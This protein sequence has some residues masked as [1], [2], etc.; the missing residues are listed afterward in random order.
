MLRPL[1]CLVAAGLLATAAMA[2]AAEPFEV[3]VANGPS[4]GGQS[5]TALVDSLLAGDGDFASVGG[6]SSYSASLS[7]LGIEDAIL[8]SSSGSGRSVTVTIPSTGYARTFTGTDADDVAAQVQTWL[9]ESGSA[10]LSRFQAAVNARSRVALLDGNPRST[11]A[12]L[13]RGAMLRYGSDPSIGG[14]G[15]SPPSAAA[16]PGPRTATSL[17]V[18][19]WR[20]FALRLDAW[21]QHLRT[22]GLDGLR[23][24]GGTLTLGGHFSD[25]V[26]LSV[27]FTGQLRHAAGAR[28]YDVGG[29]LAVPLVPVA[30]PAGSPWR[31]TLT[32]FLQ[33]GFGLS[34]DAAAGGLLVGG[35]VVQ[36]LGL[37]VR[38]VELG[39]ATEL[40]FYGGVPLTQ[41]RGYDFDTRVRRL[42]VAHSVG[43][44]WRVHRAVVLDA[45]VGTTRLAVDDAAVPRWFTPTV[46]LGFRAGERL[47]ARVAWQADLAPG[48]TSHGVALELNLL[49]GPEG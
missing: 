33:A 21:D 39:Y 7:Y 2:R 44:A 32:P 45:G 37:R 35:G 27:A 14:A 28:F 13:A 19:D 11:A 20:A 10:E 47:R 3:N 38:S 15:L 26:G 17:E 8:V 23:A 4:A 18:A 46:G 5:L 36:R 25:R 49:A 41:V 42:V 22:E 43:A 12:L 9:T 30:H 16:P 31:W 34:I 1:T 29:E 24:S 40:A 48:Y 6:R